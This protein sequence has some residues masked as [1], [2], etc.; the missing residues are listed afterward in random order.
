MLAREAEEY[1]NENLSKIED[2]SAD[3]EKYNL[4]SGLACLSKAI[5]QHRM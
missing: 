3:P 1:F 5:A 2:K 4:Y